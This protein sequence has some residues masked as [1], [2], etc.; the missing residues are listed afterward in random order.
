MDKDYNIPVLSVKDG[1]PTIIKYSE[2]ISNEEIKVDGASTLCYVTKKGKYTP[3]NKIKD[4]AE[5]FKAQF[6]LVNKDILVNM[7]TVTRFDER[8]SEIIFEDGSRESVDA[9][10]INEVKR[11]LNP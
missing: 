3:I 11:H 4:A 9:D 1:K 6:V 5:L 8:R 7:A 2:V 10:K